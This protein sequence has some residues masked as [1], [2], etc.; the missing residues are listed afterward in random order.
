MA[1]AAVIAILLAI[2]VGKSAWKHSNSGASLAALL[3]LIVA[4]W[5]IFAVADPAGGG[6]VAVDA[7]RGIGA[8]AVGLGKIIASFH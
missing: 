6:M 8:F 4:C 7:A 5:L 2:W 3:G 1:G